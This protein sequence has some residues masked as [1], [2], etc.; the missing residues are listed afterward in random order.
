M[1][2]KALLLLLGVGAMV[3]A[4]ALYSGAIRVPDAWNP[5]API[6]I[7]ESPNWLT[8]FKLGRLSD[9]GALCRAV[10]EEAEMAYVAVPDRVTG[11]GCGF[12][13]AVRIEATTA[14]VGEPFTLSC[15]AAVALAIW[16]RHVLQ[17]AALERFGHPVVEL[18]HFGSYACRGVY[19]REDARRSRHATADALDL[20]GFV[21][22]DGTRIRV[23]SDWPGEGEEAG[24]LQDLHRG[25]YGIFDGVLG[26]EYNPAHHDHFHFEQ[27]GFR[28]CR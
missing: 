12:F 24:F 26:P 19:G 25:A 10:L 21:L 20:A 14:A 11:P 18:E 4:Y 16:E 9:D 8:G 28:M 15:R 5:W 17:P 22:E 7:A 27:G 2:T 23:L 6:T 13:D 1:K 3:V